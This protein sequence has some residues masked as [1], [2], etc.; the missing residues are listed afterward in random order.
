MAKLTVVGAGNVGAQTAFYGAL[1]GIEE[2]VLIDIVEGMPQGKALDIQEAMPVHGN[3]I[4]ISGTNDYADTKDSDVVVITAG[5][6]R[7]PGMSRSDLIDTNAKIMKSVVSQVVKE[8]PNCILIIVSNPLDAMVYLAHKESGFPKER[9]MGM[10]GVLDSTRF[11]T[12]LAME[13]GAKVKDIE[14]MVLGGHG[15]LMVPL[16]EHCKV[17]G[18][19]IKEIMSEDEIKDIVERTKFGGA[20]IVGLLKTGS[21]FFAPG[22]SIIE[23]VMSILKDEKKV[24]PCAV[25]L[26][27]EYGAKEVFAGVPVVL[28]KEGVE[29]VVELP[30]NKEE[31]A[32]FDKS[33]AHV[34][35]LTSKL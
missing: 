14:A 35:E 30:L 31:Q 4:K 22:V 12:F 25:Y 5:I 15:D 10:A 32:A 28:G 20:E 18:K 21:A 24:L 2:I 23:M 13:T 16:V 3:D 17:E 29:K 11:R 6:A 19:S 8:S 26:E 27:G 33:V 7:K 34:K 9:I 1:K